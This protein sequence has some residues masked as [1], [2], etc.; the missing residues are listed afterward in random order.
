MSSVFDDIFTFDTCHARTNSLKHQFKVEMSKNWCIFN[1]YSYLTE[2][3]IQN[4]KNYLNLDESYFYCELSL[5]S[6]EC[7]KA[8]LI[9]CTYLNDLLFGPIGISSI[10]IFNEP[11]MNS[12][13]CFEDWNCNLDFLVSFLTQLYF[14]Y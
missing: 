13:I 3:P 5:I 10:N 7:K 2:I 14:C 8:F 4:K 6:A 11:S 9:L 1:K 12:D